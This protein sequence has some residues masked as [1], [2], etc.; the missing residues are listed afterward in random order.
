MAANGPA[1]AP[2]CEAINLCKRFGDLT[3]V[4]DVSFR[5]GP[6]EI[7]GLL[8][9]NGAGKSTTISMVCGFLPR[10][11]GAITILSEDIDIGPRVR[12]H[13]GYVPQD[14]A[15]FPDLS[16][17]ENLMF[18]GRMYGLRGSELQEQ[19]AAMLDT[20]GLADRA[21]DVVKEYSGGMQRRCN[22]AAGLL[23]NPD[24]L[25]LDEPTVGVDPQSRNAILEHIES[26]NAEGMAV[27]YTT[28]YMEE[29]ERLCSRV[30]IIDEGKL[31]AEGTRRELVAITGGKDHI[32]LT[33]A[34]GV[35]LR[36]L[37]ERALS[38]EG[39]TDASIAGSVLEVLC[40]DARGVLARLV[41]L[42]ARSGHPVA[43]VEVAE[44]NLE[45]V[46]LHLTGKAL[47]D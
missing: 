2:V 30:G 19:V 42:F 46:F 6:G 28:H 1:N 47:R 11:A 31:I 24:L 44:P 36:N 35:D 45:S 41:E 34:A 25:V 32:R 3:A 15:L 5:I 13:L 12:R 9:P 7:Y 21:T 23:H 4:E 20:V 38:V 8:G 37:A 26:L 39:V 10:D 29:A 27:L 43:G 18:W 17:K 22:I 40:A 16:G 14:I 33:F